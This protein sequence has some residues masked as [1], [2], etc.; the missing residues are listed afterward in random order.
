MAKKTEK[1]RLVINNVQLPSPA[2]GIACGKPSAAE[3]G[4]KYIV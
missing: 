2:P 1:R 4:E 3:G